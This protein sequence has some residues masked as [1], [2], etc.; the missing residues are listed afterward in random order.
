MEKDEKEFLVPVVN[1]RCV[2]C[3]LCEKYC[4]QLSQDAPVRGEQQYYAAKRKD[5]QLRSKSQSGGAFSVFA[6][7]VLSKGGVVYGVSLNDSLDAVYTRI[8]NENRLPIIRGSKYVQA[9]VGK[10][11][12]MVQQDLIH[13]R[14]VL[15]S[16]TACHI[17]GLLKYLSSKKTG[18]ETLVTVDI[19]CHGVVSPLV[20]HDYRCFFEKYHRTKIKGFDF[21]DK[22]FGWHGHVTNIKTK[23][24][25]IISSDYVNV[26]YSHLALRDCCYSCRYA[27]LERIS[28]ITI[29]DCWGIEK[30]QRE[31]DDNKGCSLIMTNTSK[32]RELFSNTKDR[33]DCFEVEIA[34]YMQP[35]LEHPTSR[36]ALTKSFWE[37]YRKYGFEYASYKYCGIDPQK[38]YVLKYT[39]T[40]RIKRKIKRTICR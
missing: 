25:N 12:P 11:F 14:N 10:V 31:F 9:A 29:G 17:H 18:T 7:Y 37:D 38:D 2:H 6:E 22:Q 8:T 1:D 27:G 26:F 32:G 5:P 19:I 40:E 4:P 30:Q 23:S 15:F 20:Y 13:H 39:G 34:N 24:D 28:D 21:R 16:G 3:G 35:N 36:P 33:F